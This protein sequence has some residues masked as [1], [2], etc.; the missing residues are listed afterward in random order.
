MPN[1]SEIILPNPQPNPNAQA[2]ENLQNKT[3]FEAPDINASQP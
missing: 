3:L 1:N 2:A